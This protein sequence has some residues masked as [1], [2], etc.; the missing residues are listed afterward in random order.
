MQKAYK[1]HWIQ[2]FI[3]T[4]KGLSSVLYA[5]LFRCNVMYFKQKIALF[6][7][8]TCSFVC[9]CC[10]YTVCVVW[11]ILRVENGHENFIASCPQGWKKYDTFVKIKALAILKVLQLHFFVCCQ[12]QRLGLNHPRNKVILRSPSLLLF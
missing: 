12:I 3:A 2:Q 10:A 6:S 9:R 4:L 11:K 1:K 7:E 5:L 8:Q